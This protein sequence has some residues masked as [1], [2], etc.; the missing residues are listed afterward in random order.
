M[1]CLFHVGAPLSHLDVARR[2]LEVEFSKAS[3]PPF[4]PYEIDDL[5]QLIETVP[6]Y[7]DG[8]KNSP[9][10]MYAALSD[11]GLLWCETR[12][13]VSKL[14]MGPCDEG[15]LYGY[16][17]KAN[18]LVAD[19]VRLISREQ[20]NE[21]FSEWFWDAE[22]KHI[23]I[24]AVLEDYRDA[25]PYLPEPKP[26]HG[27]IFKIKDGYHRTFQMIARGEQSVPLI[28]GYLDGFKPWKGYVK[29]DH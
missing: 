7:H 27:L 4:N 11:P 23:R 13:P 19:F 20:E 6:Q 9:K 24:P 5:A 12:V 26:D 21:E 2:L 17:K 1:D 15:L 18:G 22:I 28:L 10:H 8:P 25:T 29:G 14:V 16:V 3:D